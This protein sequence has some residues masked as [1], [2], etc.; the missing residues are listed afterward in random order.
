VVMQLANPAV[1]HGVVESTVEA[2]QLFRHPLKRTRTTLTYLAV[3]LLGDE[4]DRVRYRRAVDR[5][6]AAVRSGPDSPLPYNAFDRQ[7]QLWVAACLYRGLEDIHVR[8]HGPL[9]AA[10]ADALYRRSA[11]LGT[12]LQVRDEDWPPDRSS[13]ERYW[14]EGLRRACIDPTVRGH[15]DIVVTLRYLPRPVAAVLGRANRFVTTGFLP[16]E[17]RHQMGYPWS[18]ADARRFERAMGVV[19]A[20]GRVLPGP[21]RRVPFNVLLADSRR[22]HR[23]GRPLV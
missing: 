18:A 9:D 7:L 19:F 12:T 17:L 21:V 2:G 10:A 5:S 20:L 3:A 22:R 16:E 4:T 14:Q 15:L 6:H 23:Q 1:G 11:S 8:L 13:F